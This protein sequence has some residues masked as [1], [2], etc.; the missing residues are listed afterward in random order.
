MCLLGAILIDPKVI[1][2]IVMALTGGAADFFKPV[3]GLIYETMV[4]LYDEQAALDVVSL[5]QRLV[6]RDLLRDV[7]GTEY[8]VQLAGSVP[9]AAHANHYAKLVREKATVRE[10]IAAAGDILYD[11]HHQPEDIKKLL[12]SAQAKIFDVAREALGAKA[13]SL[14]E[15]L[16]V[17][18]KEIES[19]DEGVISGVATGFLDLDEMT[20]GFQRGEMIIIAARPSMGK[21]AL[22]LN[23]AENMALSNTPVGV[24]SMEMGREQLVY[25]L[26]ASRASVDLQKLRRGML[27]QDDFSRLFNACGEMQTAPLYIDDSPGLSIVQLRMKARRMVQQYGV[28]VV[29]VDY[30]QL[31]SSGKARVE[32]RQAEVSDISRGIKAMARELNV[33]VVCLSQLN[34]GA[35][36]REGHRPRL[37]DLRESGAI[38][39]D[40]DVVSMLHREEYY[41]NGDDEWKENHPEKIGMA[42]LIL[43]KQRNGPVGTINLTWDNTC[44]RFRDHCSDR[45]DGGY[46]EPKAPYTAGS[47][48]SFQPGAR[49][50][51][52]GNFR[53]G[54][55]PAGADSSDEVTIPY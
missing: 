35:E 8:L 51:P 13:S 4:E 26:L 3:N 6:D 40:A 39:Q 42:E 34:R 33:P 17:V 27:S 32:S 5:N 23:I 7:G 29:V 49:T 21:T 55:G 2:E 15:L 1:G 44:T 37:S 11:A 22:A 46:A 52:V 18:M 38:E 9:S 24:F 43:A 45:G 28:Q 10:L 47:S 16:E 20:H 19:K 54:G 30:L 25:R 50:G 48:S 36:Q 12:D 31:M 14:K 41:H 53:D